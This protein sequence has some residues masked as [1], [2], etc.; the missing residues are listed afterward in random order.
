ME[1]H[2]EGSHVVVSVEDDGRGID[3]AIIKDKALEK[4]I[5]SPEEA[6]KIGREEAL[7]LIFRSGFSTSREVTDI[8]GRG[9]GMDVV[10]A[11]IEV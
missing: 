7:R 2:H 8:S 6:D 10:K 4:N 11:S 1:A 5:I 3:P 9:V